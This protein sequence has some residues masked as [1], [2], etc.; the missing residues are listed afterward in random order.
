MALSGLAAV[1]LPRPATSDQALVVAAC[2][3]FD[4]PREAVPDRA[5]GQRRPVADRAGGVPGRGWRPRPVRALGDGLAVDNGARPPRHP[6]TRRRRPAA[7]GPGPAG[8]RLPG[9]RE[10]GGVPASG[11]HGRRRPHEAAARPPG[12][13]ARTAGPPAPFSRSRHPPGLVGAAWTRS[14]RPAS[15]VHRGR[16]DRPQPPRGRPGAPPVGPQAQRPRRSAASPGARSLGAAADRAP[17]PRGTSPCWSSR[18]H[19]TDT[20]RASVPAALR[21]GPAGAPSCSATDGSSADTVLED[22]AEAPSGTSLVGTRPMG[23][24]TP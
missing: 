13:A 2:A 24:S 16:R 12:L 1:A 20:G 21:A 6:S 8:A 15:A 18:T 3:A 7:S 5:A 19:G 4:A 23:C 14:A 11:H 10:P 17:R 9:R 22:A